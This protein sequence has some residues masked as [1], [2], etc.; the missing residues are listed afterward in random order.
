MMRLRE[1]LREY[2]AD[3]N[4]CY[5]IIIIIIIVIIIVTTAIIIII[6]III[7]DININISINRCKVVLGSESWAYFQSQ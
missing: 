5:I 2:V 1:D 6:I 7:F 4:R 3:I